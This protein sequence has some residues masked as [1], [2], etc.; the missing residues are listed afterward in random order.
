LA[1]SNEKEK[2]TQDIFNEYLADNTVDTSGDA[3]VAAAAKS[4]KNKTN[5]TTKSM[6]STKLVIFVGAIACVAIIVGGMIYRRVRLQKNQQYVDIDESSFMS[7]RE[8][9]YSISSSN[10]VYES[11]HIVNIVA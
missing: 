4:P 8:R 11:P 5:K 9:N 10:Q 1:D 7:K 6:E 2:S 3:S